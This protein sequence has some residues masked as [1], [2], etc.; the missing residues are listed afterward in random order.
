M[1]DLRLTDLRSIFDKYRIPWKDRGANCSRGNVN[2]PCPF[3]NS[4][5]SYHL[6]V[7][8]DGDVYY[9]FRNPKHAGRNLGHLFTK[10][11]IPLNELA[12]ILSPSQLGKNVLTTPATT[13][14]KDYSEFRFF[15][16]AKTSEEVLSYLEFR[17][18]SDPAKVVGMFNLKVAKMG[19]WAGRLIIPLTIGWT[20]RSMRPH[21]KPRYL[22]HTDQTGFFAYNHNSSS[23]IICEGPLDGMRIASVSNSFDVIAKCGGRISSSILVYLMNKNYMSIFNAPDSDVPFHNNTFDTKIL[24]SFCRTKIART[25][26]L[27]QGYKDT[28]AMPEKNCSEWLLKSTNFSAEFN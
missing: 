4:D 18:F 26:V 10:L 23:V 21:I 7:S 8:E 24:S 2:I 28:A 20:G 25:L 3:C 14:T 22:A 15:D 17:G 9:C 11:K 1:G 16:S 19:S 13:Q 6:S 5:P 12:K 27:P